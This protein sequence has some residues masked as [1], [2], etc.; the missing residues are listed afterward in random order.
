MPY[1]LYDEHLYKLGLDGVLQQCL[2]LEKVFKI[3]EDFHERPIV[4][5]LA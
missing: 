1:T 4:G 2:F 5:I 3:L